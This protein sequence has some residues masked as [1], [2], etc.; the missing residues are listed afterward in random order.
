MVTDII[1]F[2]EGTRK[3]GSEIPANILLTIT[4]PNRK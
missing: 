4:E 2:V 3:P 1:L